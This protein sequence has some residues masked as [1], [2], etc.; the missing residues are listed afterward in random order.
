VVVDALCHRFTIPPGGI[1]FHLV[2]ACEPS[3]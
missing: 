2:T 3:R 1:A